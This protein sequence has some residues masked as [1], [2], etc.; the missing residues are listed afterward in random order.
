MLFVHVCVM[1]ARVGGVSGWGLEV[2]TTSLTSL[3]LS[4]QVRL[5]DQAV[6]GIALSLLPQCCDCKH[7]SPCLAFS[8][9]RFR[10]LGLQQSSLAA[11][12]QSRSSFC[13]WSHI[14]LFIV[15]FGT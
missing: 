12:P 11:A 1:V 14:G 3:E 7:M 2:H 4:R 13:V 6:P 8:S 15:I 9:Y 10:T 5:V